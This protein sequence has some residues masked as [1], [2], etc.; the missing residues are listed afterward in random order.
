MRFSSSR[1]DLFPM[2]KK[3]TKLFDRHIKTSEKVDEVRFS[4][5]QKFF[6]HGAT[7]QNAKSLPLKQ[8]KGHM[9][10]IFPGC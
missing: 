7:I 2:N 9:F 10:E 8:Q 5:I 4:S 1:N 6:F 3:A